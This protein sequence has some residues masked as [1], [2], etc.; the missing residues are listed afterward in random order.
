MYR[1]FMLCTSR[2]RHTRCALVT[3]VQTC[4]LPISTDAMDFNL[5]EEQT[6]FRDSVAAFADRHLRDGALARAHSDDYPWDVAEKM[7]EAGLIGITTTAEDGGVG[8]TL[9]DAVLAIQE[10][11]MVCASRADVVQAGNFR[12]EEQ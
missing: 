1:V 10:I 4:A 6:M 8:G 9:M 11:A 3:G 7:A 12:T 2:R 5:T